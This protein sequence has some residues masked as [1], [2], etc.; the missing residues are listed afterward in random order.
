[1]EKKTTVAEKNRLETLLQDDG[2]VQT[3]AMGPLVTY[4]LEI[5]VPEVRHQTP[6]VGQRATRPDCRLHGLGQTKYIDDMTFPGMLYARIK[7]AGIASARIKSIDT[8]EAEAMP[9]VVAVITGR[10]IP[11]NSFGPSLKDQPVLA[12]T[13]VF[14]AGD[15]VAA[16]AAV[17][18]QIANDALLKIKVE[19]EALTPVLDPLES[20]KL[21]TPGVHA[22]SANIY[23]SKVIKKGDVAKGFAESD[24]IFEGH[25]RTQMV[26]HVPLEPHSTIAMWDAN[27]R[28]SIYS[29]LGRITL[30]RAD[31]ARTLGIPMS[32]IRMIATIVGGN[33]GGK[34][35]IT[36]EPV[37]ALLSKKTGRPVKGTFTRSEEFIA[38]TT[39]HPLIMDYKTGVTKE[40]K[41]LARKVRLVLDGG[42]YCSWSETTL[43]KACILSAGPYNI[44]NLHAEAFVVYTN[45]TMTGAMRGFGAPQ[46]CFAY[47][48]HMDDIA[49][50]LNID[51]LDI[52]LLNAFDEGSLSPTGQ[53]LQSVVVRESLLRAAER[54][55]WHAKSNASDGA[56]A[57]A[58]VAS[59]T[60]KG[61][62]VRS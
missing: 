44:E 9:G 32:R 45:K 8:S 60:I 59:K 5:V 54:F 1:M 62:G 29:T 7:R 36:T 22:P 40:G 12:D 47:E 42:A 41:I 33:F 49:T 56:G 26:E 28:L 61:N 24:H 23:G 2:V 15:G 13:R 20:L 48:S 35:E 38:S 43:G 3:P 14:H 50:A 39:R 46:V 6:A 21:E 53:T 16:V 52:R 19:Y 30:G 34:N 57:G 31:V 58:I 51:P 10:D 25:F 18:E 4:P 17:T 37:L 27:G 55:G 11:C